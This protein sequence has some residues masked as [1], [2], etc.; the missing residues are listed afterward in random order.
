MSTK[1]DALREKVHTIHDLDKAMM[2][3]NWDRETNMPPKGIAAR[4][5]Q[6]TTLRRLSHG[7]PGIPTS[8][9]AIKISLEKPLKHAKRITNG[10]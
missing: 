3:L 9:P 7:K 8:G 1:Y 10:G 6:I 5:D 4:I 2:L